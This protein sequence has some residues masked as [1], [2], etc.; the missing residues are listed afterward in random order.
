MDITWPSKIE[1]TVELSSVAIS[2]PLLFVVTFGNWGCWCVPK[3]FIT[4]PFSTGQGNFPLLLLK[5]AARAL[6]SAVSAKPPEVAG[7]D[8]VGVFAELAFA[9]LA[10]AK[11][12][13]LASSIAALIKASI[14]RSIL[15]ASFCFAW[16]WEAYLLSSFFR[17]ATNSCCDFLSCVSCLFAT[18]FS[19]ISF[20]LSFF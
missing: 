6:S 7:F 8:V 18:S 3:L 13:R 5:L 11:A 17:V 16:I 12:I 19:E 20:C 10:L 2:T 4:I 9:A 15:L 1:R 14:S